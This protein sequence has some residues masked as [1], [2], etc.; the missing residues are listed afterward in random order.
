MASL[1][2]LWNNARPRVLSRISASSNLINAATNRF[3]QPPNAVGMMAR[4]RRGFSSSTVYRP[5]YASADEELIEYRPPLTTFSE[6][7]EMTRQAVRSWAREELL[8]V[9]R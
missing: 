4:S 9:V 8:P 7:E 2:P 1:R 3:S 6:D 5:N